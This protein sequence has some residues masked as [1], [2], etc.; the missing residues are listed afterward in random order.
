MCSHILPSGDGCCKNG[1]TL[2][3]SEGCLFLIGRIVKSFHG[4]ENISLADAL[5][6]QSQSFMAPSQP[7]E[8]TREVLKHKGCAS[9][10]Q[11]TSDLLQSTCRQARIARVG[12]LGFR[13]YGVP[14]LRA[15]RRHLNFN[16]M[17]GMQ[18]RLRSVPEAASADSVMSFENPI[19][20]ALAPVPEPDA[21]ADTLH[22]QH[23]TESQLATTACHPHLQT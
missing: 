21:V 5:V 17:C 10:T 13:L 8:T 20:L 4:S 15:C 2:L 1:G 16:I 12:R 22:C 3:T 11:P 14:W 18:N 6:A 7:Q 23:D 19:V 9:A